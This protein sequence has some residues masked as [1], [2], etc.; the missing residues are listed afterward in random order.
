MII[1][2]NDSRTLV[3]CPECGEHMRRVGVHLATTLPSK[4]IV[5]YECD[6]GE[7]FVLEGDKQITCPTE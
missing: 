7:M 3:I 4:S 2:R 1:D 5:T 6:C